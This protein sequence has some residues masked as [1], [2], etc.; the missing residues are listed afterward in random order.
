MALPT[1]FVLRGYMSRSGKT[2]P[3]LRQEALA[4]WSIGG[5]ILIVLAA[6]LI[7]L[8]QSAQQEIDDGRAQLERA[9]AEV[10]LSTERVS[11]LEERI[12]RME[13]FLSHTGF[14]L[15]QEE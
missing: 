7:P 15:D 4:I 10:R 6:V 3:K 13:G 12:S 1:F 11:A 14:S 2:I 5:T 9:L 8:Y